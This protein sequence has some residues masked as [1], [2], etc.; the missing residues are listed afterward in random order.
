MCY[1]GLAVVGKGQVLVI[2]PLVA[3][4][5]DQHKEALELGLKSA[6]IHSGLSSQEKQEFYNEASQAQILF[7]T[8][9][10][11]LQEVFWKNLQDQLHITTLVIDEAHCLSQWG[12]D[13]RP[14][15]TRLPDYLERLNQ[16][17]I[18]ALTATATQTVRADI[19]QKVSTKSPYKW[20]EYQAPL[21]R[22]NLE[23]NVFEVFSWDQK[24][25]R[26]VFQLHGVA[27]PKLIYFSLV[28]TLEQVAQA[29]DTFNISYVKYHGQLPAHLKTKNQRSF[30]ENQA[31]LILATPA[32]GLGVNKSNIRLVIHFEMPGSV[33]AYFQEVGRA[34]RDGLRSQAELFY[35]K[36]DAQIH[37]DF[38]KWNHPEPE[39]IAGVYR[40][41]SDYPERFRQEGADFLREK[42]NFYNSRDF[43]VETS[44]NLLKRWDVLKPLS[45]GDCKLSS[46]EQLRCIPDMDSVFYEQR[47]KSAQMRL[48]QVIQLI[49][50]H[51]KDPQDIQKDIIKYFHRV[52]E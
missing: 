50:S 52:A 29:L 42:M 22:P 35:A 16:P 19:I 26:L 43:R 38:L 27:G 8:P 39:F 6:K 41:I 51:V 24:I 20:F 45:H 3:L 44:L 37:L 47:K 49:E 11:L 9:E 18:M 12:N 17:H 15:Y 5:E 2:S 48:L 33:E 36:D 40:L 32:F 23:L 25:Q 13:F 7:L 31:D 28:Q 10:R 46:Y 1:Q 21:E 30:F 4:I 14:D 34:G